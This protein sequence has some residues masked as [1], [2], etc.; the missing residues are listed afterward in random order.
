MGAAKTRQV[1]RLPGGAE[2]VRERG[3][4][5]CAEVQEPPDGLGSARGQARAWQPSCRPSE[6]S[7]KA[8]AHRSSHGPPGCCNTRALE[9]VLPLRACETR[10]R[11]E[12][13]EGTT[14]SHPPMSQAMGSRPAASRHPELPSVFLPERRSQPPMAGQ[15]RTTTKGLRRAN[16]QVRGP[17][18]RVAGAGFEPA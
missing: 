15:T 18:R 8:S 17:F 14:T 6:E 5:G 7:S 4:A 13:R 11:E 12:G 9:G 10:R 16:A 3:R 2:E 1:A